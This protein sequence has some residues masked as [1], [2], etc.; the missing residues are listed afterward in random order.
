MMP[1]ITIQQFRALI[2]GRA[3]QGTLVRA[4]RELARRPGLAA[5]MLH[6]EWAI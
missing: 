4:C 2:D 3:E 5:G 6:D 1:R